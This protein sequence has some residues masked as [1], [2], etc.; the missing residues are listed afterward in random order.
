MIATY[1]TKIPITSTGILVTDKMIIN[2]VNNVVYPASDAEWNTILDF[3]NL[4]G[5]LLTSIRL[6][7]KISFYVIDDLNRL[8]CRRYDFENPEAVCRYRMKIE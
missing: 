3:Y 2:C 5:Q 8:Y 4:E 6:K 7:E 1:L